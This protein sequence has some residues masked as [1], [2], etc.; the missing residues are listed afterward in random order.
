MGFGLDSPDLLDQVRA[1]GATPVVGSALVQALHDGR[2]L[3]GFLRP[4]MG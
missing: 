1:M 2:S 4:R 3:E